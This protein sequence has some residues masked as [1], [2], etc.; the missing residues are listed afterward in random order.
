MIKLS[1]NPP[2]RWPESLDITQPPHPWW[3]AKI[4]PRQEKAFA[5]DCISHETPYYLPL[6]TKVTRRKDNNKPRKSIVCLFSGYISFCAPKG[7]QNKV[8]TTDRVVSVLEIRNQY[9]FIREI[10]Q[11]R[12]A[13]E[14][15]VSLEP[16]LEYTPG[17]LV[18]IV[19]GPMHGVRGVV[20]RTQGGDRL[21]L[22]VEG[23]GLAAMV[24][25][26]GMVKEVLEQTDN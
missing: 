26:A 21:V 17:T 10:E 4:K 11:I 16:V 1:D 22:K 6:I 20:S 9:H 25:G 24:V 15:G 18:E 7:Q 3:I 23:L 8:F 12:R 13:L 5:F 19:S 14:S 2:V